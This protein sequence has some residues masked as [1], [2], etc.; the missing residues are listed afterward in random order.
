MDG[1]GNIMLSEIYKSEKDK[2]KGRGRCSW[3]ME[4]IV[5]GNLQWCQQYKI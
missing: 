4:G 1:P 3:A 2:H 5:E